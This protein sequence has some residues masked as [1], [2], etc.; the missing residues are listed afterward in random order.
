MRRSTIIVLCAAISVLLLLMACSGGSSNSP[1]SPPAFG[2]V[3]A[4]ISDD[5]TQDWATIG[6]KV[7]SIQLVPQGGGTP[8]TIYGPLTSANAPFVNLVQLDQIGEIIG[9]ASIQTGTYTQAIITVS[10]N[11]SD[12]QL[13]STSNPET[14]FPYTT[15]TTVPPGQICVI[16]AGGSCGSATS[17]VPLTINLSPALAVGSGSNALD[18]EFNLSHP[19]FI[20]E[21]Y[22]NA[23]GLI[24]ALNFNPAVRHHPIADIAK[25]VLRHLYGTNIS[26]SSDFT[27]FTMNKIF[28]GVPATVSN[29]VTSTQSLTI[30]ADSGNVN[31]NGGTIFWNLDASVGSQRTVISNFQSVASILSQPGEFV[32]VQARYQA[33]GTLVAVRVWAST[34]FSKVFVSPEGHVLNVDAG[35]GTFTITTETGAP[36][37]AITVNSNTEF[38]FNNTTISVPLASLFTTP[39]SNFVR[40]FKVHVSPVDPTA[41]SPVAATVNIEIAR[42]AGSISNAS[43]T[44]GFTYTRVF[45]SDTN[46]SYTINLD[47]ISSSTPNGY[48]DNNNPVTGF[49]WWDFSQPTSTLDSGAT[50]ISD[51][52]SDV[53][54][55]VS[56][57]NSCNTTVFGT[58]LSA[59]QPVVGESYATWN[60]PASA[61]AWSAQWAVL[62]PTPA[63]LSTVGTVNAGGTSFTMT[64]LPVASCTQLNVDLDTTALQATLA[65][66][67]TRSG[68]GIITITSA[69]NLSVPANLTALDNALTT[70]T[71]VKVYG[72]PEPSGNRLKAYVLFY[73]PTGTG[74]VT[75]T[76]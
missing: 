35:A 34:S 33:G 2:N 38:T 8:V 74:I 68:A 25:L 47:Y 9:N 45:P 5:A 75:P 71:L 50:A 22:T 70:G 23:S 65:Y 36:S 17:T 43:T 7:L 26:V 40:G 54:G 48:D 32:R 56:Y 55:N 24:W 59:G 76:Q 31:G 62:L 39:P 73:F 14:G 66:Q 4:I 1:S 10:G 49:K 18:L 44:S 51:F 16:V 67:V 53:S 20:V 21:H 42:Y 19:A 13:I 28:P 69:G 6:V 30:L 29:A 12:I 57:G 37:P 72:V 52:V 46:D 64:A 63:P 27:N 61:N 60:D 15:V 41:A 11:P 58:A 3:N